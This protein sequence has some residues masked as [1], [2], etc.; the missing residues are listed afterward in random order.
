MRK[1]MRLL[2]GASACSAAILRWIATAQVTAS[3]TEPNSASTPSPVSLTMRPF[4]SAVSGSMIR[5]RSVLTAASVVA[6][7]AST[8]RE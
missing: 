5:V 3:T 7:S 2:G 4:C 8:M 1:R 6:S